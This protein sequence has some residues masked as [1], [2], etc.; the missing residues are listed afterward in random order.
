[1]RDGESSKRVVYVFDTSVFLALHRHNTQVI[2][3][4]KEIWDLLDQM[5][6]D[7]EII[8]HG[9]VYGEIVNEK[10][11]KPDMI[12][13]WLIPKKAYFQ[14]ESEDQASLVSVIIKDYQ[15]LIDPA[16]EKEQADPWVV[17]LAML[18]NKQTSFLEDAEYVVVTQE[19]PN[20]PI[21]IPAACRKYGVGCIS[22]KE[23]FEKNRIK[24]AIA[25]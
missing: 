2:E 7:G 6:R 3:L 24:I 16:R 15:K 25:K 12:T 20:S 1:M 9:F 19:N 17:A 21:K 23:F 5:M 10:T 11:E 13:R 18:L 8:S 22:L 4:P 14:N